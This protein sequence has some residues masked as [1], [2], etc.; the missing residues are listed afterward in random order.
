MS[1]S[2][3]E[4]PQP[5]D[6]RAPIEY[7]VPLVVPTSKLAVASMVVG[8]LAVIGCFIPIVPGLAAIA[9]G[10]V[11][12]ARTGPMRMAGRGFAIAGI[13]LGCAAVF[14][15]ILSLSILLPSVTRARESANRIRCSSN[16]S[17]LGQAMLAY[18]VD[19][20][21]YPPDLQALLADPN[22]GLVPQALLCPS[23]SHAA[24]AGAAP[25][26]GDNLSF[27]YTGGG[28][29]GDAPATVV[30]LYE[31]VDHH[32]REGANFLFADGAV[33]FIPRQQA[34][35][36]IQQLQQGINPPNPAATTNPSQP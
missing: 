32:N 3:N 27:I 4:P 18:A 19:Y 17:Q 31:P 7:A 15:S 35:S 34:R 24:R 14:F 11:A 33:Q 12:I 9:M 8:I 6:A 28:L 1:Y 2:F 16:M 5:Q 21:Q 20:G 36:M 25:T 26:F 23:T 30:L 29:G 13:A 22:S 10:L